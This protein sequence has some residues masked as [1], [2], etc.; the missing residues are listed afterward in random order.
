MREVPV[1]TC[2]N[3]HRVVSPV[4]VTLMDLSQNMTMWYTNILVSFKDFY[5]LLE[6]VYHLF[7]FVSIL[8]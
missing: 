7:T 4:T 2:D 1:P 6:I 8:L 5:C 3:D